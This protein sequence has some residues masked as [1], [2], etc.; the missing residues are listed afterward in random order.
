MQFNDYQDA[1][2]E[3]AIYPHAGIRSFNAL[4]YA[5]LGLTNE[6]GEVAGK[7]KKIWRDDNGLVTQAKRDAIAAELGDV[8]WYAARVADELGTTLDEI[9]QANLDKLFDRKARGV[10]GGSGDTR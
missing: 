2:A 3:T 4:S 5:V 8:L 7:L 10:I 1:T 6:S 9:A